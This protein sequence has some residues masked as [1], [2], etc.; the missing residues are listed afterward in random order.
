MTCRRAA[1][2]QQLC[3]RAQSLP[4][5]V[6]DVGGQDEYAWLR[7]LAGGCCMSFEFAM[8]YNLSGT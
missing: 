2:Q 6:A 8:R 7:P 4:A 1:H 3:Q 5:R